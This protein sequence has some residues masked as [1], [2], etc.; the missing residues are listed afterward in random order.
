MASLQELREQCLGEYG[1]QAGYLGAEDEEFLMPLMQDWINQEHR[2]LAQ[3]T[4]CYRETQ[5]YNLTLGSAGVSVI[6]LECNVIRL[7]STPENPRKG[8][9]RALVGGLWRDLYYATEGDLEARYGLFDNRQSSEPLHYFLRAGASLDAVLQVVLVPGAATAVTSGFK[10]DC[11]I[12]PAEMT[13]EDDGPA[14]Q[15]A[16]Q[17]ALIPRVCKRMALSQIAKGVASA[18]AVAA[19]FEREAA[20]MEM[21]LKGVIQRARRAGGRRIRHTY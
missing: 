21:D 11:Y 17:S 12:Y 6:N 20:R 1:L 10:A 19:H 8:K 16:Q 3:A 13:E 15:P 4:E 9:V 14:L 2:G 18:Q 7:V 5:T